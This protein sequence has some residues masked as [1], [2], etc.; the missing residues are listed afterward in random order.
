VPRSV[1]VEFVD[2]ENGLTFARTELPAEQLPATFAV[3]TTVQLGGDPWQV[4]RAE[5]VEAADIVAAGRL[6]LTVRRIAAVPPQDILYSLPT[7]CDPLPAVEPAPAPADVLQLHED[8]WRQV[9]LISRSLGA[10][11][12]AELDAVQRVYEESS[13]RDPDGRIVGFQKIHV[14]TMAPLAGPVSRQRLWDLLPAPR[15]EHQGVT[16]GGGARLAVG[17][18]ALSR[19]GVTWYGLADHDAVTVLGLQLDGDR[20]ATAAD[21]EPVLHAFDLVLVDWCRCAAVVPEHLT[22]YLNS[23][24][25]A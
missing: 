1:F 2:A 21:I 4:Q 6:V 17:S 20:P 13:K 11:A 19:G 24:T 3:D 5:P 7:I 22:D 8:E 23:V 10:T 14:R 15:H 12:N 25:G 18:F 16:F 9:E